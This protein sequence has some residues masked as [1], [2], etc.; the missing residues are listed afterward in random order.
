[1]TGWKWGLCLFVSFPVIAAATAG[2][3]GSKGGEPPPSSSE[4]AGE[5][6][7]TIQKILQNQAGLGN[8]I[9]VLEGT[10][11]GWKGKCEESSPL[12]RS[13]WILKDETGCI[14]VSGKIPSG[15]STTDPRGEALVLSGT[16][17]IKEGRKPYFEAK[18]VR[19]KE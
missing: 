3:M 8:R 7:I 2:A 4:R 11:Q 13:D 5:G 16:L 15:V 19:L 18:E 10:F 14:Y 9:I 17:K 6:K 1:M 12:T